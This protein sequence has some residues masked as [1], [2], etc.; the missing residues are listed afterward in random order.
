[1]AAEQPAIVKQLADNDAALLQLGNAFARRMQAE[2]VS[3]SSCSS[4]QAAGDRHNLAPY[5]AAR[6]IISAMSCLPAAANIA[7]YSILLTAA[8][9]CVLRQVLGTEQR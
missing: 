5:T 4:H 6:G 3:T 9:S 8:D 7:V 1:M 2:Q